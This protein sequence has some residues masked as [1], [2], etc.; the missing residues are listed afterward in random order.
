MKKTLL[1]EREQRRKFWEHHV[2]TWQTSG[3][4]Q[5]GYCREHGLSQKSFVYWKKRVSI[6]PATLSLVELPLPGQIPVYPSCTPLRLLIGG[7][8]C[9]EIDRGFD[10]E[11]LRRVMEVL[12]R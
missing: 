4:S 11:T 9:I 2:A 1:I 5:M 7:R 3:L 8:Y 6:D 12:E 10:G